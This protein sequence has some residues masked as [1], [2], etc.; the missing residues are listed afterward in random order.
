MRTSAQS[1]VYPRLLSLEAARGPINWMYFDYRKDKPEQSLLTWGLGSMHDNQT[2]TGPDAY[3]LSLPWRYQDGSYANESKIQDEYDRLKALGIQSRGGYAYKDEARLFLD[4]DVVQWDFDRNLAGKIASIRRLVPGFD[5]WPADAQVALAL[6]VW[7]TGA[8]V[9]D[10]KSSA[11]WESLTV[12][13]RTGD[14]VGAADHCMI[15]KTTSE[16]NRWDRKMFLQAAKCVRFGADPEIFFGTSV[17]VS[18]SMIVNGNPTKP[19]SHAFWG[20]VLL[21]AIGE[22]KSAL[23]GLFGPVSLAAWKRATG[24]TTPTLAGLTKLCSQTRS[25]LELEAGA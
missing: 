12:P 4:Q 3:A 6:L 14:F 5:D 16:R 18:A 21:R 25:I 10:P 2:R 24:E 9:L 19:G 15:N 13:L 7:N 11:Y 1:Q 23:D 8:G 22:Y 20:Q 17:K